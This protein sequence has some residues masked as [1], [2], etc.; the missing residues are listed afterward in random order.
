MEA[1]KNKLNGTVGTEVDT[2]V[3]TMDGMT[4]MCQSVDEHTM[5]INIE[6]N[7]SIK[8]ADIVSKVLSRQNLDP[9]VYKTGSLSAVQEHLRQQKHLTI[10]EQWVL[11]V[12]E[13]RYMESPDMWGWEILTDHMRPI[14]LWMDGLVGV[15]KGLRA[16]RLSATGYTNINI[17]G[18]KRSAS[19]SAER[20]AVIA[21]CIHHDNLPF[22]F[23]S[24]DANVMDCSGSYYTRAERGTDMYLGADNTEWCT[25]SQNVRHMH[26]QKEVWERTHKVWR[27]TARDNLLDQVLA[28]TDKIDT[29][30]IEMYMRLAGYKQV[31]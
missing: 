24:L 3:S 30:S 14:R 6:A 13:V 7:Q 1:L 19:V 25:R 4:L 27:V 10:L 16:P 31:K 8:W 22:N 9:V 26:I 2:R 29:K 20:L 18:G 17:V 11:H 21:C 12:V 5:S 15:G 23:A 28:C